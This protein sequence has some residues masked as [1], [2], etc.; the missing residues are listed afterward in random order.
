MIDEIIDLCLR[1]LDEFNKDM[2]CPYTR[3]RG[4]GRN[5]E[6]LSDVEALEKL[7]IWSLIFIF[8]P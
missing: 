3:G 7:I 1:F 4:I 5:E 2:E 6:I 8:V